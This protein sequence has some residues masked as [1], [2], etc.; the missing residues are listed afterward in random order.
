MSLSE[1]FPAALRHYRERAGLSQEELGGAA[2]LD[3]SY[4][5]QL[6]RGLKSP[7]LNTLEKLS[8]C[9]GVRA[10]ELLRPPTEERGPNFPVDYIVRGTGDVLHRVGGGKQVPLRLTSAINAAHTLIDDLY[11]ID[12]DVAAIL[13]LRNLSAFIGELI[14]A[15]IART[16][17]GWLLPNPHQDGYPDLLLMDADGRVELDRLKGRMNE[18]APFSPFAAG[19]IEIKATCGSVPTPSECR[20]RNIDRP[21]LGDARIGCLTGYDWKS[22]HRETNNLVGVLWDFIDGRPRVAAMFYSSELDESDWGNIVQPRRGGGRTTS[23][24]IMN[25][26]GIR[27]MHA[28]WLCVLAD[29]GY[30]AFINRRSGDELIPSPD[31]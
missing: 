16:S 31:R 30:R 5:S 19:G 26:A 29:G 10:E 22:H 3:R 21:G 25:R 7:T 1:L 9:L 28:G 20:R 14:A 24:S 12:L 18:K 23:V 13:G 6:E 11:R 17:N 2:G 15:A 4:L 8:T 27:K